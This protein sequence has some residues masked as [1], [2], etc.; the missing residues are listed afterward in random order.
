MDAD[1][2]QALEAMEARIMKRFDE[3]DERI[4]DIETKLLA[5]FRDWSSPIEMRLRTLPLIDQRLG[6]LEERVGK[7]ERKDLGQGN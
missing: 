1:T 6:L 7:L 3:T 5:A 2:K 4:Y